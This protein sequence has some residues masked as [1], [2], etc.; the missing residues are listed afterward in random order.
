MLACSAAAVEAN[1]N[2]WRPRV[3]KELRSLTDREYRCFITGS[4]VMQSLSTASGRRLYGPKY[5]S[6]DELIVKHAVATND[7][8]GDQG[9]NGPPF[10]TFH[11]AFLLELEESLLAICPDMKAL[12]YW[13]LTLDNPITGKYWNT[14]NAIMT[15]KYAGAQ[16]GNALVGSGVITGVW[17]WRQ[18][19][20][21]IPQQWSPKIL[22]VYN[23]S[24]YG[25]VRGPTNTNYNPLVTRY[26]TANL[27]TIIKAGNES[28]ISKL[29]FANEVAVP[30]S[31]NW[32]ITQGGKLALYYP[33][34][35]Y[36]R[37]LDPKNYPDWMSWGFCCDLTI[38]MNA[39]SSVDKTKYINPVVK[40]TTLL[41]AGPHWT[42][43]GMSLT[44]SK[45][46]GGMSLADSKSIGDMFDVS[47][48]PNEPLMF[49]IHHANLD[50]S[51]MLWQANALKTDRTMLAKFWGYPKSKAEYSTASDGTLLDDVVNSVSPFD[52]LFS[53]PPAN[54]WGYTHKELP[55][56]RQISG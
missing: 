24:A 23:G 20:R 40:A 18:V 12:P 32:L 7:P 5:I 4:A 21:F 6:Y 8:R 25:L 28:G 37:C 22:K 15:E 27:A 14:P 39:P 41:H 55:N 42:T 3:R 38:L 30:F 31:A 34:Q 29:P 45:T 36:L 50:R 54:G 33:V 9:H 46:T 49:P 47:T 2:G 35:N 44:D 43:G 56:Y 16:D 10:M 53:V 51:N 1:N 52:R 13:D 26:P 48:S 19:K 17:A 11:R